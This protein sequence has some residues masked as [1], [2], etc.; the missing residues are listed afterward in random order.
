MSDKS[1]VNS[2]IAQEEALE[3]AAKTAQR[4]QLAKKDWDTARHKIDLKLGEHIKGC[5]KTGLEVRQIAREIG[6]SAPR[7][8]QL[9]DLYQKH[10]DEEYG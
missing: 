4:R 3:R 6:L 1:L 9:R 5:F 10:L 7:V 2:A 8:Y